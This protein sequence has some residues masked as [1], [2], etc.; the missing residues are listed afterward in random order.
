MSC[1]LVALIV[2]EPFVHDFVLS[3]DFVCTVMP[4]S[5]SGLDIVL[6]SSKFSNK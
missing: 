6:G 3:F 4:V 1:K 5:G 2:S